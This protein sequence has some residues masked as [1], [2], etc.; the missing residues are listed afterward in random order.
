MIMLLLL[1]SSFEGYPDEETQRRHLMECVDERKHAQHKEVKRAK[2][3]VQAAREAREGRQEAAVKLAAWEFLGA[4][5]SQLWLLDDQHLE[6]IAQSEHISTA[7][8]SGSG[9]GS[10]SGKCS[11]SELVAKI[12][13]KKTGRVELAAIA[14]SSRGRG[15]GDDDTDDAQ[16]GGSSST[17]SALVVKKKLRFNA[18][19]LPSNLYALSLSELQVLYAAHGYDSAGMGKDS[20][21]SEIEDNSYG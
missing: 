3:Q 4:Q 15:R 8:S 6:T 11:R 21:I 2:Q 18:D 20:I 14:D 16:G 19:S 13:A 1:L 9:S 5:T 12:V 17:S 7:S 10:G